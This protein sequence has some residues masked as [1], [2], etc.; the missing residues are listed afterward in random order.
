MFCGE[1]G[2]DGNA[3][4]VV[5]DGPSVAGDD[6]QALAARLGYA[7]TVFVDDAAAGRIEIFAP[8]VEMPFAGHPSVG[9]AWLLRARGSRRSMRC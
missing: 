8:D 4:G 1:G 6:R 9:T 2:S 7:E 3:L 5:L